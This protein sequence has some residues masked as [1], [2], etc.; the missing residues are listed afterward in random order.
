MS[1]IGESERAT[2]FKEFDVYSQESI[3]SLFEERI[4]NKMDLYICLV[5]QDGKKFFFEGSRFLEGY[6]KSP[7]PVN[8]LNRKPITSFKIIK[9]DEENLVNILDEKAMKD[10][11]NFLPILLNDP[12]RDK[13]DQGRIHSLIAFEHYKCNRVD[14]TLNSY[15]KSVNLGYY[16][17]EKKLSIFF[18]E[19]NL[20]TES[21]Y[22]NMKYLSHID[23][24]NSDP[25]VCGIINLCAAEFYRRAITES[26]KDYEEYSY[27]YTKKAALLGNLYAVAKL[28]YY[29]ENG[30][31]VQESQ[32]KSLLWR[33]LIP[34]HWRG[35]SIRDYIHH[36]VAIPLSGES[37]NEITVPPLLLEKEPMQEPN[38][39]QLF[40][41]LAK[42]FN[43]RSAQ[44]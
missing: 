33:E 19:R 9:I 32:E 5:V 39:D 10:R 29:Y 12:T 25:D 27:F 15:L 44:E 42:T 31:G 7:T 23:D 22:W 4:K 41:E 35:S 28:I 24:S 2:I 36:L 37:V 6:I 3:E 20:N 13:H 14:E 16:E 21:L 38:P 8:P 11:M 43:S 40:P 30:V 17:A 34:L 1:S 26:N 18:D